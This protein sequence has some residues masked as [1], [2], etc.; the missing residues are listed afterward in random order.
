MNR[1]QKNAQ[2]R[3]DI[4]VNGVVDGANAGMGQ[5]LPA[6]NPL[7]DNQMQMVQPP[8]RQPLLSNIPTGGQTQQTPP[9]PQGQGNAPAP[10]VDAITLA[11]NKG[12]I[13]EAMPYVQRMQPAELR[14]LLDQLRQDDPSGQRAAQV[15]QMLQGSIQQ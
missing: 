8:M 4:F 9:L 10:Q 2:K 12:Q 13:A 1:E 11:I 15:V 7:S 6:D 5:P 3:S 14:Q